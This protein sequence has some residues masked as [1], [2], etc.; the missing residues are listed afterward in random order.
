MINVRI[1]SIRPPLL[2]IQHRHTVQHCPRLLLV[3]PSASVP[4]YP[5]DTSPRRPPRR[6][7]QTR[8]RFGRARSSAIAN[9]VPSWTRKSLHSNA[10]PLQTVPK[11][12]RKTSVSQP[13]A[14]RFCG[15]LCRMCRSWAGHAK[16]SKRAHAA[17]NCRP[18]CTV[19]FRPPASSWSSSSAG[20]VM[21]SWWS[22]CA[23][24]R[25]SYCCHDRRAQLLSA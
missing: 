3:P 9:R 1:P 22:T 19:C 21:N 17:F 7:A 16:P 24:R 6:A 18:S 14:V 12:Q 15:P 8:A 20:S 5:G 25:P 11:R 23:A 10:N 4:L 2:P 13:F